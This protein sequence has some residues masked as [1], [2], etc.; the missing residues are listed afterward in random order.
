MSLIASLRKKPE[1]IR[2]RIAFLSALFITLGLLALWIFHGN[3]ETKEKP[4]ED[5]KSISE[6]LRPFFLIFQR[7]DKDFQE[8]KDGIDTFNEN[9]KQAEEQL[10]STETEE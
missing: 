1:H 3:S 2:K 4:E 7:A 10:E 8:V 9:K 5:S 6:S